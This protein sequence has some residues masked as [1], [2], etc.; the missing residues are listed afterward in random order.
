MT[1]MTVCS[2]HVM[3]AFQSE[4]TIYSCL[5]VKELHA[6]TISEVLVTAAGL[7]PTTT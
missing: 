5:N 2:Y 6:G 4:S 1:A 3:Y 7:K